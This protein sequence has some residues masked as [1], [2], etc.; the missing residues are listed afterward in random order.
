MIALSRARAGDHPLLDYRIADVLTD[1]LPP[2]AFDLVVSVSMVHHARLERV[3]PR[4]IAAVAP[5]GTLLIQD[6]STRVGLRELPVNALA[7]LAQRLRLVPGTGMVRPTVAALYAQHGT[8]RTYM[9]Q[10]SPTRIVAF[11]PRRAFIFISNGATRS[12]GIATQPRESR[13]LSEPR[14]SLPRVRYA[15]VGGP[16]QG[17]QR[18]DETHRRLVSHQRHIRLTEPTRRREA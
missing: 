9:R 10:R 18:V 3:V 12:F 5:G 15:A 8:G 16:N 4:L 14:H 6:V 7:W 11:C 17:A 13:S 1:D 2:A